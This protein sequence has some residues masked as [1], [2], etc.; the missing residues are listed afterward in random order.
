MPAEIQFGTGLFEITA[1]SMSSK[2][3]DDILPTA[4]FWLR[5]RAEG[6]QVYQTQE[7]LI[8]GFCRSIQPLALVGSKF[9]E[10]P[11]R[12]YSLTSL[13]AGA[14]S[15]AVMRVAYRRVGG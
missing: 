11:G 4:V 15:L 7:C 10:G 13:G 1:L 5:T 14:A 12:L 6:G 9:V 2:S 8:S 3:A